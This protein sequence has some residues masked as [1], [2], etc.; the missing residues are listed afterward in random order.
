M[1]VQVYI[2]IWQALCQILLCILTRILMVRRF[3]WH[4]W[5]QISWF[6]SSVWSVIIELWNRSVEFHFVKKHWLHLGGH[7]HWKQDEVWR[8][9]LHS[10]FLLWLQE[11]GCYFPHS[12]FPFLFFLFSSCFALSIFFFVYKLG[13]RRTFSYKYLTY[14]EHMCLYVI[15]GKQVRENVWYLSFRDIIHLINFP[16]GAFTFLQMACL[17]FSFFWKKFR[18]VCNLIA[19]LSAPH[20]QTCKVAL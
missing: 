15:W 3:L 19:C 7:G 14:F 16:L 8:V 17:Y 10:V 6:S 18:C 20:W 11:R 12:S 9:C 5:G 4:T 1:Q 13:Y 2:K